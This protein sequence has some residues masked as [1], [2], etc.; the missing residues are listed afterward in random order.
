MSTETQII[1]VFFKVQNIWFSGPLVPSKSGKLAFLSFEESG[2]FFKF[3]SDKSYNYVL[4]DIIVNFFIQKL[5]NKH[6]YLKK[7]TIWEKL[8]SLIL[9]KQEDQ[10]TKYFAP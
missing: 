10:R 3:L 4:F 8:S 7:Y 6:T 9:R 2:L 5:K 1:G